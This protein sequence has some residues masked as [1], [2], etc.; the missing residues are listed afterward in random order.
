MQRLL[1]IL[2]LTFFAGCETPK[3][4]TPVVPPG[5]P[6]KVEAVDTYADANDEAASKAGASVKVASEAN[7]D[8]KV[9][10]VEKELE[11]AGALLPRPN[12]KDLQEARTRAA[13]GDEKSYQ[14]AMI[15]ADQ[16]NRRIDDLWAKVEAQRAEDRAKANAEIEKMQIMIQEERKTKILFGF[17]GLGGLISLIG[18]GCFLFG[19]RVAGIG[20]IAIGVGFGS[21]GFI[22]G[23]PLFDWVM[24]VS[25][26]CLLLMGLIWV[27]RRVFAKAPTNPGA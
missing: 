20:V 3:V 15:Y 17:A 6:P 22:W 9:K 13:S 10:V 14:A 2:S 12:P 18:V 11:V 26:G 8:G 25:L 5:N 23:T 4:D 16:L 24:G 19:N 21:L 1:I 27:A 7:R